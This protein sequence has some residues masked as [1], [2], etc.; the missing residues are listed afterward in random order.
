MYLFVYILR[1]FCY[2]AL[3]DLK[4]L[5]LSDPLASASQVARTKGDHHWV[6]FNITVLVCSLMLYPLLKENI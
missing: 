1:Q 2:V 3:D 4:L 6:Q 5:G